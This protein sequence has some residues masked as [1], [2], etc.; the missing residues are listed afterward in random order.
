MDLSI[1]FFL[2]LTQP[3]TTKLQGK[4][5]GKTTIVLID[6]GASHKFI[7]GELV[8]YFGLQVESTPTYNLRL[9]DDHKKERVGAI[10][11]WR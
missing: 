11:R 2:G 10:K 5:K 3:N 1:F 7:S 8:R 4:V 9:G 6:S